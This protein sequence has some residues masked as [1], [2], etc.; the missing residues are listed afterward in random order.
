MVNKYGEIR[1]D[2]STIPLVGLVPPGSE[3]LIQT[4]WDR[5]VILT[6]EQLTVREVPRPYTG[7]TADVPWR[8]VFTNL[9]RK[10]RSVN[11]SQ[12]VRMLPE[13]IRFYVGVADLA[14]RKERLQALIHWM[15][16]YSIAQIGQVLQ[17]SHSEA[18]VA[19]LTAALGLRQMNRDVAWT[20]SLSPPGTQE[21]VSLDRYDR[22]MGVS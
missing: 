11:H 16:V 10:P 15:D 9:L 18:T 2:N 12:F 13:A 17:E 22:L 5:L 8:Q 7:K 21:A 4:F 19:Q 14:V 6:Q 3:V 20:E 1:V